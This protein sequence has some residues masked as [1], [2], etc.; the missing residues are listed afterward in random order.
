MSMIDRQQDW[1][2]DGSLPPAV[3]EFVEWLVTPTWEREQPSQTAWAH[4]HHR[5][6]NTVSQWKKDTRVKRAIEK[7]CDEL[8]LSTDRIQ[9][10]INS[11]FK[12]ATQGDMKAATLYL[13]HA[14]RLAPKRIVIED[15]TLSAMSDAELAEQLQ[16]VGLLLEKDDA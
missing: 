8:N 15:R 1:P 3:Q 14:D 12:A 10:V 9:E 4:A 7:R 11:V 6:P 5:H 13:Q 16:A 2:A